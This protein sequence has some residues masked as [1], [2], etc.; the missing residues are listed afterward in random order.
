MSQEPSK[1]DRFFPTLGERIGP[2]WAFFA[3]GLFG[4]HQILAVP[5]G[6]LAILG[7]LEFFK[8]VPL[9]YRLLS[10]ELGLGMTIG[11]ICL[12]IYLVLSL[13]P[14]RVIWTSTSRISKNW[15][16]VLLR[17]HV[18]GGLLVSVL[19]PPSFTVLLLHSAFETRTTPKLVINHDDFIK[20]AK[21]SVKY[22]HFF[23]VPNGAET[24]LSVYYKYPV[25]DFEFDNSLI[26]TLDEK[27]WA[28]IQKTDAYT[29][30]LNGPTHI[31]N[32]QHN[33]EAECPIIQ[34]PSLCQYL[35]KPFD[36]LFS[37]NMP[38]NDQWSKVLFFDDDQV[39]FIQIQQN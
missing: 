39:L 12:P 10:M 4:L 25:L 17:F 1:T 7:S 20:E 16:R 30:A 23:N 27:E 28:D 36:V 8:V 18:L 2:A 21:S 31:S 26:L 14:A 32:F 13:F 38:H 19:V 22:D 33:D 24:I 3:I 34:A 37:L 6:Y 15:L 35:E 9:H 5:F 11:L 29:K